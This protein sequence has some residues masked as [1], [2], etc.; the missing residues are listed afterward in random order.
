MFAEENERP[1]ESIESAHDY[2]VLTLLWSAKESVLKA[3][4]C[5]LRVDTRSVNAAPAGLVP[6]HGGEWSRMCALHMGGRTYHGWWRESRDLAYTVV[7]NPPPL[8]LV[9][10]QDPDKGRGLSDPSAPR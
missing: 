3:L 2:M 10:L 8:R 6:S 5:G 9:A 1:F 7:A 4:G